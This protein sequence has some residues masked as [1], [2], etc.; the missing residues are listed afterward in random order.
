L[1]FICRGRGVKAVGRLGPDD[2]IFTIR[3]YDRCHN[4]VPKGDELCEMLC[5]ETNAVV[6][7]PH[8]CVILES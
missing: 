1:S 5:S 4:E 3:L 2:R 6:E 8:P 7:V